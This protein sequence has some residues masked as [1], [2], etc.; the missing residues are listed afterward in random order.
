MHRSLY[1]VPH[2][3][4]PLSSRPLFNFFPPPQ[5]ARFVCVVLGWEG[6][7]AAVGGS[8]EADMLAE[9]EQATSSSLLHLVREKGERKGGRKGGNERGN[10]GGCWPRSRL[11][12]SSA[13]IS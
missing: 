7:Q 2:I 4:P 11:I 5:V 10:E 6:V 12:S 8:V 1:S 13:R 9:P 3:F